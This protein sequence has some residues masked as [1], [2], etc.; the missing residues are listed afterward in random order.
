M[1]KEEQEEVTKLIG[2]PLTNAMRSRLEIHHFK[3]EKPRSFYAYQK[4]DKRLITTWTGDKLGDIV[5]MGPEYRSNMGDKRVPI[6]VH[7]ING[8]TYSGTAYV[9]AGDYVR[10]QQVKNH[11]S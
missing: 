5:Q 9:G 4:L 6:R 2:G 3:T 1:S 8:I 7:G 10:L 11:D